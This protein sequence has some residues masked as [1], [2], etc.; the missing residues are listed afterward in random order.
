MAAAFLLF[1]SLALPRITSVEPIAFEPGTSVVI[2]G[3]GFGDARG[4]NVVELDGSS[5]TAASYL[6]WTDARIEVVIPYTADSGLLRVSGPLGSSNAEIVVSRLKTPMPPEGNA[7]ASVRPSIRSVVPAEAQVGDLVTI[8]GMSFGNN[9]QFSSVRFSRNRAASVSNSPDKGN[10]ASSEP[11]ADDFVE[12]GAGQSIYETWDDKEIA[13]RVP[14]EAGSGTLVVRTPQGESVP[15]SFKVKPG[16]GKKNVYSPAVYIIEFE[17]DVQKRQLDSGGS[18]LFYLPDPVSTSTQSLDS[19]ADEGIAPIDEGKKGLAVYRIEG[20]G[21]GMVETV[22][23]TAKITVNAVDT[24]LAGYK[25]GFKG[26][27]VPAFLTPFMA[28]EPGLPAGAKEVLSLAAK[29]VGKETNPQKKAVLLWAWMQKSLAWTG[30]SINTSKDA[31]TALR[32]GK[33]DTRQFAL[34]A[35]ALFRASRVPAEPISGLLV[36]KD[37]TTAAH[38][39]MEYYLPALGWVPFDP[40]LATGAKPS[41]FDAG[42]DDPLRYFGSLDNRHIAVTRGVLQVPPRLRGSKLKERGAAWSL[43]T[44]Y[45]ESSGATYSSAWAPVRLT[46]EY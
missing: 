5:L 4:R 19:V 34:L 24:D 12:P 25:D 36:K 20:E 15:F 7:P 23:R 32:S 38:S 17:I 1:R 13:V 28:E 6:S 22:K 43:Q 37:G 21:P 8:E 9:L 16:S 44:L 45:E 29:I 2:H 31:L 42:F 26:S 30:P 35:C 40:V 27:L 14:E 46:G 10:G 18:I 11:V 39:W 33:A 41:G 3:Q